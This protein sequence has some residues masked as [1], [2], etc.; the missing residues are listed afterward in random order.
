MH[1]ILFYSLIVKYRDTK[2]ITKIAKG[3]GGIEPQRRP[4]RRQQNVVLVAKFQQRRMVSE[5]NRRGLLPFKTHYCLIYHH[6][7]Q[8]TINVYFGLQKDACTWCVVSAVSSGV[9]S[10]VLSGIETVR[11]I[12]GLADN[13]CTNNRYQ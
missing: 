7:F 10:A 11:G 6:T 12:I 5:V 13:H 2:L 4:F 3:L 8:L 9:G 1:R